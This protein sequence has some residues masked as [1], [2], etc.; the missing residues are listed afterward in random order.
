MPVSLD[1]F[2]PFKV[3][4]YDDFLKAFLVAVFIYWGWDLSLAVNEETENP[5]TTPGI[6]AVT[7]TF[8]LVAVYVLV[9]AAAISFAGPRALSRP[10]KTIPAIFLRLS[11]RTCSVPGSTGCS[12]LPC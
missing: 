10:R 1:W 8:L 9:S 11:G 2:N 3:E 4:S 6:A 12:S 7:S 5:Q